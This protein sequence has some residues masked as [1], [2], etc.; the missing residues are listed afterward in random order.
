RPPGRRRRLMP[1]T[2]DQPAHRPAAQAAPAPAVPLHDVG[3]VVIGRNE[4]Q[5]L[6]RCL[7][8]LPTALPCV[9][10]ADSGSSDGSPV[11]ARALGA[12]VVALTE[13]P[14]TASRGRAAGL[15][16]LLARRPLVEFVQF[17][18]GD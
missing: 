17:V 1:A 10:Y 8:S 2:L 11:L 7:E 15:E 4:G 12:R 6:R 18:D 14:F 9:V 13:G 5:R 3:A 16:D